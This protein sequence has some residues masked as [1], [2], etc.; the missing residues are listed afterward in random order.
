MRT[1]EL[2]IPAVMAA[3]LGTMA[4]S[5][6]APPSPAPAA[7]AKATVTGS[8]FAGVVGQL[9][10]DNGFTDFISA[11]AGKT[12]DLDIT[13]TDKDFEGGQESEFGFFVVFDNCENLPEGQRPAVG[14]CT[15]TEYN[16]P[17][18]AG[19]GVF[20]QEAGRRRLRG[21]FK[22]TDAGGPRQGLFAME[23]GPISGTGYA[24]P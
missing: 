6:Q 7:P 10:D 15:G 20:V 24:N 14:P 18:T 9:D 17:R 2:S 22:V 8:R 19:A 21:R 3:L 23:L 11:H 13:I 5:R 4:C 16:I 12:V 1:I